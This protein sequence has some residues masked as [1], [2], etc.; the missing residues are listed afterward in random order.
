MTGK[1]TFKGEEDNNGNG[2]VQEAIDQVTESYKKADRE[3]K[4]ELEEKISEITTG[5]EVPTLSQVLAKGNEMDKDIDIADGKNFNNFNLATKEVHTNSTD[6]DTSK[7][8]F[9]GDKTILEHSNSVI[10]THSKYSTQK[11]E[12]DKDGISLISNFRHI[13]ESGNPDSG[14]GGTTSQLDF[15]F[16][17]FLLSQ[18]NNGQKTEIIKV[19]S[20]GIKTKKI[21]QTEYSEPTDEKDYVTKKYLDEKISNQGNSFIKK[22]SSDDK[23]LLGNGGEKELS[24]L[25]NSNIQIGGRNLLLKS[26]V[27]VS[28]KQYEIANWEITEDIDLGE[29]V[30][31]TIEGD[32][33]E[34]CYPLL[35]ASAG[36]GNLGVLQRGVNVWDNNAK[37]KISKG[38]FMYL[39]IIGNDNSDKLNTIRKIKLERGNKPTDWTPAPEDLVLQANTWEKQQHS[40]Y[41]ESLVTTLP[42]VQREVVIDNN[43]NSKN[44][45]WTDDN[46]LN[47]GSRNVGGYAKINCNGY[48][49]TGKDDNFVLTAGG[50]AK[51]LSDFDFYKGS[52]EPNDLNVFKSRE[53]G[54]YTVK[55]PEGWGTLVNFKSDASTSS[56]ELLK[57]NWYP[58][59]RIG[60]R[61]SVDASRFNDDNGAFRDLAWYDDILRTGVECTQNTTLQK[62]H[63]NQTLFVTVSCSIELNT[64]DDLS[65]VSFRKVFDNGVV[66]FTCTGKNIIYTTENQFNGKKGSTAVVSRYGNDCYI[67]I[68]NI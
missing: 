23:V 61:N 22:G 11:I 19:D 29:T 56:I 55:Y 44:N 45:L 49:L 58:A 3:L 4:Q 34:G 43:S 9:A 39:Y 57:R 65:S 37:R 21:S 46:E 52:I 62:E 33:A 6:T 8:Y 26:G 66:T 7:L 32:F 28:N 36:D 16:N 64:I 5:T 68:R 13:G 1:F 18:E 25:D 30:T 12:L 59:T 10:D 31:F 41:G 2:N 17:G 20:E 63:Q 24:A 53:T 48:K 35:F 67:D 27:T 54:T 38:Q 47:V 50:G 51:N 15:N 60:V 14:S 42:S 40:L